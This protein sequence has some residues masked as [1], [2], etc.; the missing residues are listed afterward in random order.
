MTMRKR[1][2]RLALAAFIGASVL[3]A[4]APLVSTSAPSSP[5]TDAFPGWN[6]LAPPHWR[7]LPLGG[8]EQIFASGFPGRIARFAGGGEQLVIRWI[9]APTRRLHPSRDC[10]RGAGYAVRRVSSEASTP[11]GASSWI[12]ERNGQAMRVEEWIV[13]AK[14]QTFSEVGQWYW[15]SRV[16]GSSGPWVAFTLS[17][18]A[19]R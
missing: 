17:T 1:A 19:G 10:L 13:D 4:G 9:D 8:Q 6:R 16:G 5:A 11:A 14:G 15:A 3:G 12:A 7:Q 18:T 2:G